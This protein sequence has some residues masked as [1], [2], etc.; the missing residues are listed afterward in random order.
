MSTA[1][2]RGNASDVGTR[3]LEITAA[4]AAQLH[5]TPAPD[6]DLDSSLD[7]GKSRITTLRRR[8]T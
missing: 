6:L 4:L 7:H 3:I 2:H 1:V 8:S 5:D